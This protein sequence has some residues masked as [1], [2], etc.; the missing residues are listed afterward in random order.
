MSVPQHAGLPARYPISCPHC[1]SVAGFPVAVMTVADQPRA[2]RL[3]FKCGECHHKW[4]H[5][6]ENQFNVAPP[7]RRAAAGDDAFLKNPSTTA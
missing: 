6:Y 7:D 1:A 5:Q 2:L 3:D 4:W